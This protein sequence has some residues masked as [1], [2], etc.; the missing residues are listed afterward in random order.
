MH[1]V[2]P[3]AHVIDFR[4]VKHLHDGFTLIDPVL[5]TTLFDRVGGR[6]ALGDP[7][8]TESGEQ[9]ETEVRSRSC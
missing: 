4:G 1:L 8:T 2:E 7:D 6:T 3:D 9:P 5:V